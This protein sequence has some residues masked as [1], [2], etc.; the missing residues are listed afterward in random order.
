MATA[1]CTVCMECDAQV[2]F[3]QMGVLSH[4]EAEREGV[5]DKPFP[6]G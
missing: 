2:I 5:V 1:C 6:F 4:K 3:R